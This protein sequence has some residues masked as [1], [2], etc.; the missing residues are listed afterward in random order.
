MRATVT[1]FCGFLT[2]LAG[3]AGCGSGYR[4]KPTSTALISVSATSAMAGSPDLTLTITATSGQFY[5]ANH[6][7]SQAVW[8]VNG[9]DNVLATTF[10]SSTML[11]AVVPAALLSNS[12]T[13]QVLVKTGD[14]MG[15]AVRSNSVFFEVTAGQPGPNISISPTSALPG[16]SDITLAITGSASQFD[17]APHNL[18]RAVW[19]VNGTETVLTTTFVDDK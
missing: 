16:S 19:L 5:D 17:N 14:P 8:F 6:N 18:S 11:T 10:V 15:S 7:L 1:L 12:V 9:T 13:A 3:L 4:S 2:V